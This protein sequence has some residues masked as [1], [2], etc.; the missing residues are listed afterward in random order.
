MPSGSFIQMSWWVGRG[1]GAVPNLSRDE[2]QDLEPS[3]SR[4]QEPDQYSWYRGL[5]HL[6]CR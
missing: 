4:L 6:G 1:Y 5:S 2:R 3:P